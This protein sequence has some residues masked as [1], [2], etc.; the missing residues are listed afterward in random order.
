MTSGRTL[1]LLTL[2]LLLGA[3]AVA[4]DA[5]KHNLSLRFQPEAVRH[6]HFAQSINTA[7]DMGGQKM[8]TTAEMATFL[9][10]SVQS[11]NDTGAR[12]KQ[13]VTRVK[14]VMDGPLM[15]VDY[16]SDDEDSDPG[17][18]QGIDEL[19]G[20]MCTMNLSNHGVVSGLEMS[21]EASAT[22]GGG[23]DLKNVVDQ[24]F[25]ELPTDPVAI[26]ETWM[27]KESLPVGQMGTPEAKVTNTLLAVSATTII[28]SKTYD[29][30]PS[31]VQPAPGMEA[32][33]FKA[34]SQITIDRASGTPTDM[35]MNL[36]MTAGNDLTSLNV[37]ATVTC[38][39]APAKKPNPT[40]PGKK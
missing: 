22:A 32:S 4:Q 34:S 33:A 18:L 23:I 14:A 11:T 37:S 3:S 26:G 19:V 38:K 10:V 1:T 16:D 12:L 35:V 36:T 9:T 2:P 29:L 20:A 21:E 5:T 30:D 27:T 40:P 8:V 13:E 17:M 15:E 7:M 39:P 6:L 25:T 28:I 31:K 24:T